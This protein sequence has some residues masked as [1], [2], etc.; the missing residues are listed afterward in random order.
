VKPPIDRGPKTP[1]RREAPREREAAR[2]TKRT[3]GRA[4]ASAEAD[5]PAKKRLSKPPP[6]ERAEKA[7]GPGEPSDAKAAAPRPRPKNRVK[8]A[9]PEAKPP[10]KPKAAK[11]AKPTEPAAPRKPLRERL[12]GLRARA[13]AGLERAQ[14]PLLF[15]GK[16]A[17]VAIT[18]VG[19]GAVGQLGE[20]H[21]R[22]SPAFAA[23][24]ITVEGQERLS[25]EDILRAAGLELGQNVFEVPPEI[26]QARL[27][28]HPWVA[29]AIVQ[30]RLPGTFHVKVREHQA[31][32]LIWLDRL[33]LVGE[34]ATLFKS[35]E[36][37]D[38]VDLPV[39]TGVDVKRFTSDRA[40]R[41]SLLLEVVAVLHD[42]R[43]A[44]LFRREPI[45]EIH[46]EADDTLSLYVGDDATE[47]RL[48]HGPY[49]SKLRKL[50]T[51]LDRLEAREARPAYVYLDNVRRPDRVTVRLRGSDVAVQ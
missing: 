33:Y 16:L 41:S 6:R 37:G 7:R 32:A 27:L 11:A 1:R 44:G 42:Y 30:R 10:K 50:R 48:G 24:T 35:V 43:A 14:K 25:E 22:T 49:R 21:V 20:R 23:R 45:A 34:D 39:V 18:V 17:L 31:S 3:P 2:P 26:A 28:R 9:P 46:V 47:V 19:I 13:R 29:E 15:T 51:V 4:R 38:P 12:L 36:P 40:R 8:V 5:A